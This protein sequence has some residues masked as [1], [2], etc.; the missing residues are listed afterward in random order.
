MRPGG[1]HIHDLEHHDPNK[2]P[3]SVYTCKP[4]QQTTP[5]RQ[6]RESKATEGSRFKPFKQYPMIAASRR[7]VKFNEVTE[8]SHTKSVVHQPRQ[9]KREIQRDD[10]SSSK[11]RRDGSRLPLTRAA[12]NGGNRGSV[13]GGGGAGFPRGGSPHRPSGPIE[14][15]RSSKTVAFWVCVVLFVLAKE[16][17]LSNLFE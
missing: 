7:L 1:G 5:I 4:I 2:E 14:A 3:F 12:G 13:D 15:R 17:I 10:S 8:P 9:T 16:K 11:Q 6:T